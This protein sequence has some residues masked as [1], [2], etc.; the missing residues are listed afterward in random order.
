MNLRRLK[1]F[2]K[3]VDVGSLTQA[4][5]V[6]HVAQPALSQQLATLEGEFK[7]QLL[8]RTQ[9]GVMPTE[10]GK[11]LYRHAQ[12]ILRQFN[13]AQADVL[14]AGRTL[15]G[16]VSVGMAPG[17][18]ASALALPLL[19]TVQGRH[20]KIV[21]HIN[22]NFGTTLC[23]VVRNGRMDMA[24][25]Y[26]GGHA[27]QGLS[28]DPL[29][30]ED[31]F[32]VAPEGLLRKG[33]DVALADL[34]GVDLLLPCTNNQLRRYVDQ[35]F[36]SAQVVPRVVAEMESSNT[37]A[38]AV[39]SGVGATILPVSAARAVA[40]SADLDLHRIVSPPIEVPLALCESDH[41]PLS[42][43][44]QVVKAI[45]LELVGQLELDVGLHTLH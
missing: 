11:A 7:Q 24:V 13:Q 14:N 23:E 40:A 3:I 15:S 21:L 45:L 1:Y 9:K 22:E 32:V 38:A 37:L 25:L 39:G 19:R 6:L 10:A 4:A 29:L 34:G 27:M 35:A 43:P 30:T 20:P 36:A 28:F 5:E 31:L 18:A 33:G 8:L 44:A 2:V 17:T 41:L 16:Q 12:I 42:E 26:G